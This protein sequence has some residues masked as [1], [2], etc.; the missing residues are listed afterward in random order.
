M[1]IDNLYDAVGVGPSEVYSES[2]EAYMIMYFIGMCRMET[3]VE[4]VQG[5]CGA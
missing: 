5:R 4:D 2:N 1:R 3:I